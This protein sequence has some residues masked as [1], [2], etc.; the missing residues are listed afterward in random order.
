MRLQQKGRKVKGVC[1]EPACR[2][3]R[4]ESEVG[5]IERHKQGLYKREKIRSDK[6]KGK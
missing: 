6:R 2:R 4:G 3:A 5:E 1:R